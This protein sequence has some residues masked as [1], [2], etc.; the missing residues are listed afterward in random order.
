MTFYT[1]IFSGNPKDVEYKVN[2]FLKKLPEQCFISIHTTSHSSTEVIQATECEIDMIIAT[3]LC[4]N[5]DSETAETAKT[6][7]G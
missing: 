4:R 5:G 3:L 1:K 7:G 6:G 2:N